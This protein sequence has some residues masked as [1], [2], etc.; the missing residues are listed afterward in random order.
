MSQAIS[1]RREEIDLQQFFTEMQSVWAGMARQPEISNRHEPEMKITSDR[2]LLTQI[3]AN[4][5]NNAAEAGAS[6]I[7]IVVARQNKTGS[8]FPSRIMGRES[9]RNM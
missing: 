7:D 5:V 1:V 2:S 6:R 9:A 4:V 3:I 8:F